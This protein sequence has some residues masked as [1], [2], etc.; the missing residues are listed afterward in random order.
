MSEVI[1]SPQSIISVIDFRKLTG[2]ETDSFSD[3]E[4][5][6]MIATLEYLS[7]LFVRKMSVPKSS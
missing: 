2:K 3:A 4:V 6:R 5:E 7:E 1:P